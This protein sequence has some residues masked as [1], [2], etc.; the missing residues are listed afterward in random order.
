MPFQKHK[1]EIRKQPRLRED[2]NISD[3]IVE[4]GFVERFILSWGLIEVS[5]GFDWVLLGFHWGFIEVSLG[6]LGNRKPQNR[7]KSQF[8]PNLISLTG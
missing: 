2:L 3:G 4:D 7:M 1:Q 5:F 8:N 6:F